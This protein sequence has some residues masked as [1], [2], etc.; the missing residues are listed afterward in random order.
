[1]MGMF[2]AR[3]PVYWHRFKAHTTQIVWAGVLLGAKLR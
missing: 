1:M 2:P 3:P